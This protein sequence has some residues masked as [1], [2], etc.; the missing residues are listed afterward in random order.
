DVNKESRQTLEN[1]SWLL[2]FIGATGMM[3]FSGYLMYILTT[4]LKA[5]CL[6]CIASASFTALMFLLTLLGRNWD[7]RG[8]LVFTG[9]IVA[10]VAL[11]ATLGIYAPINSPGP[12]IAN[13]AGEVGPPVTNTS[14][15]AELALARHLKEV[16][17]KM[18]GAYWCP[19]CHDQKQ[20]FGEQALAEMPYIE[21]APDGKNSQTSLCQ[22]VEGIT[23]FPTWEVKGQFLSGTQTL[24]T[25]AQA[26]GY[27]GPQNFQN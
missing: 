4:E 13:T 10:V 24:E 2:L 3:V 7:D 23:G 17:A 22:S 20:L 11:V 26:S 1:W 5:A 6:Y 8:Q 14:G 9:L 27:T 25:L 19:H 12:S 21:C 18:Y 16:D 15:E